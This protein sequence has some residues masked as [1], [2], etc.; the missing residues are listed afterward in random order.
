MELQRSKISPLG[1]AYLKVM[2]IVGRKISWSTVLDF[3]CYLEDVFTT[4]KLLL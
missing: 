1:T 3:Q 4:L 2:K